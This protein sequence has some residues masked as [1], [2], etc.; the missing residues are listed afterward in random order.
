MI[1]ILDDLD[2]LARPDVD[3]RTL[4]LA[5]VRFGAEAAGTVAR[6]RVIEVTLSPIVHRTIGGS[7][8]DTEYYGADGEPLSREEVIE[9]VFETEGIVHFSGKFSYRIVGG[10]VSGFALYGAERGLLA[11]FG[12]L[13]SHDEFLDLF[14]TPDLVEESIDSGELMGYRHFYRA[15]EK[16]V[17]W[18]SLDDRVNSLNV[19]DFEGNSRRS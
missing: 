17:F 2:I 18:D 13:R 5:G 11:H 9:N 7:G 16:Q 10:T 15:A 12:Y 19:G 8:R 3:P 4:S 1:E 14:G 6:D